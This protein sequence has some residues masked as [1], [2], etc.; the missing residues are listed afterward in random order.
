MPAR[1][2]LA[3]LIAASVGSWSAT[4]T[5]AD[6]GGASGGAEAK[7]RASGNRAVGFPDRV[8][9]ID[10]RRWT[11]GHLRGR[12]TLIDFWATWCAPCLAELPRLKALR[13]RH[14]REDFEILGV[15]LDSTSRRTVVSWLNRN[16]VEWPQIHQPGA[17]SATLPLAFGVRQLPATVLLDDD[18]TIAAAGLR[19]DELAARV[20]TLVAARR[21]GRPVE[22][23]SR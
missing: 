17:Y 10:G 20:D 12:V 18:G 8:T 14:A 2:L 4:G 16:R 9:D 11:A 15:M 19:G 21:S 6:A 22:R 23:G 5:A 3:G 7:L 13:A 1:L